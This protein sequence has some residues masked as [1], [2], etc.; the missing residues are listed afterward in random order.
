MR[1]WPPMFMPPL[2]F[3]TLLS[4][5]YA[6]VPWACEHQHRAPL[7]AMA[8]VT[9]ALALGLA[10]LAWREWRAVGLE[11]PDDRANRASW[12]RL[13]AVL[14]LMLSGLSALATIALWITQFVIPPCVR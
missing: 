3:L 1:I 6:A 10:L 2:A 13:L 9:L 7:H 11:R 12:L 5:A 14:G 8:G 4:V